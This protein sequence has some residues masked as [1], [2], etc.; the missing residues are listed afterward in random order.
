MAR[1]LGHYRSESTLIF[2]NT[3][4][5]C[6]EVADALTERA[7]IDRTSPERKLSM[8]AFGLAD[9]L[10]GEAEPVALQA[11]DVL[12]IFSRWDIQNRPRVYITG[13]VNNPVVLDFREGIA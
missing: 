2:C 4:K 1:I 11:R 8:V 3:K 10:S 12:E 9:M 6:Q 13:E 5:E 7:V